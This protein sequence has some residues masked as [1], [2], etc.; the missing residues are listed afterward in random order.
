SL[1]FGPQQ[2]GTASASQQVTLTNTGS[3]ALS[4]TNIA[5]TG[6]NVSAFLFPNPC[7]SSLAA[8]A[9]C[10][11]QGTFTPSSTGAM[12][13]S[14]S[15]TDNA[16]G[17]PQSIILTGAGVYVP[18]VTATPLSSSITTAQ[19][20]SIAVAVS[21]QSGNPSPTGSVKVAIGLYSSLP[22][23]LSSG[24]ASI[25]V[26]AGSLAVGTDSIVATYTP[27]NASS[28]LYQG[29]SGSS[30]VTVTAAQTATAPTATTT[31]ASNLS[32]NSATLAGMV[33][34]NGADTHAW[35]LYGTSSTLSGATQTASQDLGSGNSPIAVSYAIPPGLSPNTTYYYQVV[36]QNS[37]G[38]TAGT[39]FSFTTI[40]S[41]YFTLSNG[42]PV[43]IAPGATTGNTSIITVTPSYG[44]TGNVTLAAAI[45][46]S[47]TGAVSPPTLSFGS[48]S[49]VAIT[50]AGTGSATLTIST[51]PA[52][53]GCAAANSRD[54]EPPWV[55][56]GSAV[57]ACVLFF[58]IPVRR[59][60]LSRLGMIAL[61]V[62]L[63]GG[64]LA[65]GGGSGEKTCSAVVGPPATTAGSYTIT[66]TGASGSAT[67][68]A[69]TV[70]L[71]VQ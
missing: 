24:S 34:P 54:R 13:A 29:A 46:S 47:P 18:T 6:A 23:A 12:S 70:A 22:V 15:I 57:L 55:A 33:T 3:A 51:T 31:A 71:T 58:G 62:A 37:V 45:T 26:P 68:P 16:G 38:T 36:A 66:V 35:F 60:W 2:V 9:N 10:V 14:I 11:I 40:P 65:C 44:F 19:A 21:G 49:P 28:V 7:G 67:A 59:R 8:G 5:V 43:S 32:A 27:D 56:A 52:F 50:G 53:V 64:V 39:I 61:L 41:P 1:S 48:T 42:T 17:S 63:A 69:A 4:I 20:L 30:S 25:I